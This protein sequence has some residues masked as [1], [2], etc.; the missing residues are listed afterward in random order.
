MA[1]ARARANKVFHQWG[2]GTKPLVGESGAEA[3]GSWEYFNILNATFFLYYTKFIASCYTC[4]YWLKWLL[5]EKSNTEDDREH[6]FWELHWVL[7]M[8]IIWKA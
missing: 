3:P 5:C 1:R 8:S 6:S 7:R 4:D 2:P